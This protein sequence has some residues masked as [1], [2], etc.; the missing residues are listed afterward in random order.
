MALIWFVNEDGDGAIEANCNEQTAK[1]M[2]ALL[3]R[4][5]YHRATREEAARARRKGW[6]RDDREAEEAALWEGV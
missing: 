5:G 2:T 4:Q 6:R 3:A 1:E